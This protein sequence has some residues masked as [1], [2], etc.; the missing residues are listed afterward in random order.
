MFLKNST[1][2]S[3]RL[4]IVEVRE[5]TDYLAGIRHLQ[6]DAGVK[7]FSWVSPVSFSLPCKKRVT[8]IKKD[9]IFSHFTCLCGNRIKVVST[10][11]V[12]EY[13]RQP[14][15]WDFSEDINL[16]WLLTKLWTP[17]CFCLALLVKFPSSLLIGQNCTLNI[18]IPLVTFAPFVTQ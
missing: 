8:I 3:S 11:C 15:H 1:P 9:T 10:K 17:F 13:S 6:F 12:A 7:R 4:S 14:Q 5:Y 18:S 2:S 16:F